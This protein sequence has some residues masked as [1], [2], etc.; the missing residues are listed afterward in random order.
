MARAPIQGIDCNV[1]SF[2]G[3]EVDAREDDSR[4]KKRLEAPIVVLQLQRRTGPP[5]D[6][7]GSSLLT[8]S[9]LTLGAK[10]RWAGLSRKQVFIFRQR[11]FEIGWWADQSD[12][13]L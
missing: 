1:W 4:S 2:L 12:S 11:R 5:F 3:D 8:G 6:M 10:P 7:P 9:L 13:I